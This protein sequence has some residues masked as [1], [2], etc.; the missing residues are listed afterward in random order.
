MVSL[1]FTETQNPKKR[2]KPNVVSYTHA[3]EINHNGSS[4]NLSCYP[5]DSH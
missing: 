5:P 2:A 3:Y 1:S 4:D